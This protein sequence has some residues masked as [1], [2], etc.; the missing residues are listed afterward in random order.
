MEIGSGRQLPNGTDV[1]P[2]SQLMNATKTSIETPTRQE[3]SGL[4]DEVLKTHWVR[5]SVRKQE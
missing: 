5:R 1:E 2:L 4:N 3:T